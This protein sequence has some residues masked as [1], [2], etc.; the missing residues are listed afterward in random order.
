LETSHKLQVS[1]VRT[2]KV[3][4]MIESN[5]Y[6]IKLPLNFDINSTFDMNDLVIYKTQ[7]SIPDAPFDISTIL[8]LLLAQKKYI[9]VTLDTQVIFTKDG[10]LQRFPI[11]ELDEIQTILE[12]L[13]G[14]HNNLLMIFG[15]IIGVVLNYTRRVRVFPILGEL[16]GTPNSRHYLC[17]HM[18]IDDEG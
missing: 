17:T 11:Y 18:I 1:S 9:N 12:L 14:H 8:S 3:L 10:E 16:M 7:Q 13:V 6:V 15:S 4:Q 5:S 2:F